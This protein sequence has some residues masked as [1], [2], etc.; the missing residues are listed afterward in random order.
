VDNKF[1]PRFWYNIAPDLPKP[2][3]PPI[4][5]LDSEY[6]L[7]D[8][9]KEILPHALIDQ[10]FTFE[11]Y[12]EIPEDVRDMYARAGRSTPLRRAK[13]F[14]KIIETPAKIY[15]KF[16]GALLSGSH[17]LNTAIAQVYYAHREG[18][19]EVVTETGAGQWGLAVSIAS[20]FMNV[21]AYIFMTRSSYATK[22]KRLSLMLENGA[23]VYPSPS[24]ITKIGKSILETDRD[25]PGSLGIAISEAVEYVLRDPSSRRYIPGSVMEY[26]LIHQTVIGLEAMDQ[27]KML[28]ENPDVLIACVGGGSNLAGLVYPFLGEAFRRG[29]KPPRVIAAESNLIPKMTKG[30]YRYEHPDSSGILPMI[31]MYTLGRDFKPP[32]V[33]AAGLRYHGVASSISILLKEGLIEP[34]SY[35]PEEAKEAGLLFYRAE[36]ILPAPES[37]HAIVAAIQE[38][39]MARRRDKE[40]TIL[41]NLSGHGLYDEDFYEV[42]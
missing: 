23:E 20:K 32:S 2:L 37:A 38:A 34:R 14:E 30:I 7:I 26:V 13:R 17:K 33:R 22:K 41:L 6:S 9:L 24:T 29:E 18:Y 15:Y 5:P 27:L 3:P 1:I 25:H 19:R 4:D 8:R 35:S 12:I 36:G 21:K 40:V 42:S 31:K 16:E 28:N 10:E 11:R 39:I